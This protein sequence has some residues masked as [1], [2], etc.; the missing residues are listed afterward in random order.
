MEF[1]VMQYNTYLWHT[2]S[3]VTMFLF[4]TFWMIHRFAQ[5]HYPMIKMLSFALALVAGLALWIKAKQVMPDYREEGLLD[6]FLLA[7]IVIIVID[8][9]TVLL[10]SSGVKIADHAELNT[11]KIGLFL[12]AL[13]GAYLFISGNQESFKLLNQF[14]D[15]VLQPMWVFVVLLAI[16][17]FGKK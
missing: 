16:I 5:T 8:F 4:I 17:R 10:R 9:L 6:L 11:F 14:L 13:I 7:G 12:V 3:I 2:F 1:C 15:V